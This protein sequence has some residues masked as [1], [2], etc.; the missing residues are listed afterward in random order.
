MIGKFEPKLLDPNLLGLE[1]NIL[2][3]GLRIDNI[4]YSWQQPTKRKVLTCVADPD[5]VFLGHPDPDLSPKTGSVFL[6]I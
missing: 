2:N 5:P 6:F 4:N 1:F 3:L